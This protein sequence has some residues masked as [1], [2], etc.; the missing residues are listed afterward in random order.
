MD[1]WQVYGLD[2]VVLVHCPL[3]Q[4]RTPSLALYRDHAWCYGCRTYLWPRQVRDLLGDA[5]PA[6]V[7]ASAVP[8]ACPPSLGTVAGWHAQ[9][10]RDQEGLAYLLGRGLTR[11]WVERAQLGHT[12]LAYS[13]P[14][15]DR[16]GALVGVKYRRD[17]RFSW[18]P[19]YWVEAG[20]GLT[21]YC[22]GDLASEV[23]LCEGEL[24]ALRARVAGFCAVSFTGGA[25]AARVD[26]LAGL[27]WVYVAYDQDPAGQR[28]ARA[29]VRAHP[30][31]SRV[32]W[33]AR[34]KDVTD[35]LNACGKEYLQERCQASRLWAR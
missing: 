7:L 20:Q 33:E 9:L 15:F 12:G 29:L 18:G 14:L 17:A 23:L 21:L 28:G 5:L 8:R 27:A 2:R 32:T 30:R 31:A 11:E 19:K 3:H 24:D 10:L 13:I 4:D 25:G 6:G 26:L 34:Y 16:Q 35:L 1:L 22:P